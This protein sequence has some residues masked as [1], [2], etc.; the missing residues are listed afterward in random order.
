MTLCRSGIVVPPP[1]D[2]ETAVDE[3]IALKHEAEK[4]ENPNAVLMAA[5]KKTT[6]ERQPRAS[7]KDL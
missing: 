3:A 4:E 6:E 2:T 1:T 7:S 5:D